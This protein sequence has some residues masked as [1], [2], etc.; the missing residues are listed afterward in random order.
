MKQCLSD[1]EVN[2]FSLCF[3][4]QSN[5]NVIVPISPSPFELYLS[6]IIQL[7]CQYRATKNHNCF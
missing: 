5:R 4:L 1:G 6:F 2:V 3:W 7:F